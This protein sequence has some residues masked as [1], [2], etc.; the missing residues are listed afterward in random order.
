MLT[1][2]KNRKI[3]LPDI[4][5]VGVAL[6]VGGYSYYMLH[7]APFA[8]IEGMGWVLATLAWSA[9]AKAWLGRYRWGSV[10]AL[11][12]WAAATMALVTWHVAHAV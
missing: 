8:G 3:D 5:F 12:P 10:L 4:V 1:A 11:L 9:A 7:A 2:R 6:L